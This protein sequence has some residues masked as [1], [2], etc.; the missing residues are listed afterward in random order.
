MSIVFITG[1]TGYMGSRLIPMLLSN[2]H[3]VMALVRKGSE[4]K[5]PQGAEAIVAD[6]FNAESFAA[7]VPGNS[8]YVQLLGVPH[9]GPK[10]KNLFRTIDLPSVKASALA[11]KQAGTR[12]FVYISVAQTPTSIMKD[13]QECRAEGEASI[14]AAG[15]NATF[16]R[17]WYVV[18]PGHYWP[19]LF[20]PL[21]KVLEFIPS[22]SAKAKALRLVY[23]DQ[24]L[25]TLVYTIENPVSG[26]RI[27]EIDEIRKMK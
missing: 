11:A 23:L 19:L 12:H 6:P 1:G 5:L 20:Q 25:K 14:E 24:M 13:Y 9:P 10:K 21:F 27:I 2:H 22:T 3:S 8:I 18:G 4:G 26:K 15:L 17:P 16:I 7:F